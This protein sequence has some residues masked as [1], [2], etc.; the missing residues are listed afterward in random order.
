M[1][2]FFS[3]TPLFFLLIVS[4]SFAASPKGISRKIASQPG[5]IAFQKCWEVTGPAKATEAS[6]YIGLKMGQELAIGDSEN[7]SKS[8]ALPDGSNWNKSRGNCPDRILVGG[9]FYLLGAVP[10]NFCV[11]GRILNQES[12]W[13]NWVLPKDVICGFK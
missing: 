3:V 9:L 6:S 5:S 7:D 1:N 13:D 4:M 10:M 8:V 2:R 11:Y 12:G